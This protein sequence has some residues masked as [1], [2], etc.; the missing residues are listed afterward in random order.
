MSNNITIIHV[1]YNNITTH[2]KNTNKYVMS[3]FQYHQY[4]II[5]WLH[6]TRT[7]SDTKKWTSIIPMAIL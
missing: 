3:L 1:K 4:F 2:P 7:T 5:L 6:L